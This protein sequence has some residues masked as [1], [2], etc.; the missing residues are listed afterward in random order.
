MRPL[1]NN[2]YNYVIE[3]N[4][5]HL[6]EEYADTNE[7]SPIEIGFD[8]TKDVTWICSFGHEIIESPHQRVRRGYCPICGKT[9]NGSFAQNFPD[10]I[11]LWSP[12]NNM[13]PYK[14]PPT[15]TGLITWTCEHGHEWQRR[16]SMQIKLRNCPICEQKN[17]NLFEYL[18][19]LLNRWDTESNNNVDPQTVSAY[20][21]KPYYWICEHGHRYQATPEFL[22]RNNTRC[23]VCSS[24]GFNN[25]N[26]IAEWHPTKNG[27]KTP[28]DFSANS[29]KRAW[30]VCSTCGQEYTARIAARVK[31]KNN[32]CPN[33]R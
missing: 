5:H 21:N 27:N 10:F 9:R 33:C 26:L 17:N 8:S 20:S 28:Y 22:M 7:L 13:D 18:P 3:N 32:Y 4:L 25:L 6:L 16:I 11:H 12:K 15:Y 30:F 2:L 24:A 19:E 14:T 23:P 31:R 29:Q 1:K